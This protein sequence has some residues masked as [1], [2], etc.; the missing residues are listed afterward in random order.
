MQV[1]H[2]EADFRTLALHDYI[3]D[4]LVLEDNIEIDIIILLLEWNVNNLPLPHC[5]GL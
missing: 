3:L 1:L 4:P 2:A 5:I